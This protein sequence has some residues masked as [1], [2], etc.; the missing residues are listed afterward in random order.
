MI[1]KIITFENINFIL[2]ILDTSTNLHGNVINGI[3]PNLYFVNI[4]ETQ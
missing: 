3:Y 4:V 2:K 1:K